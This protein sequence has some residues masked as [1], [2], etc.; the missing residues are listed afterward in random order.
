MIFGYCRISTAK[1]N[2]ERQIRNILSAY[3]EAKIVTEVYTGTKFQGRKELDKIVRIIQPGDTIIFDSVSRMSRNAEEGFDLY[4]FLFK[5]GVNLVFLKEAHINTDTYKHSMEG[6]LQIAFNSKDA[7]MDRLMQGI[8]DVLNTYILSLARKQIKLA[9]EQSEKEVRDLQQRT[10][11]GIET[12]RRN[13]RQPGRRNGISVKTK[14]SLTAKPIILKHSKTF[15]GNL[16]NEEM[17]KLAGIS[18]GSLKK[19]KKELV[20]EI[21]ASSY[22]EVQQKYN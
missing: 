22:D 10:R 3:P 14:K 15:G 9:F 13:G 4:E 5:K 11:E 19:Y 1:Q 20:E 12:A 18:L 21:S 6:Q 8:V 2:I 17:A 16:K 7:D